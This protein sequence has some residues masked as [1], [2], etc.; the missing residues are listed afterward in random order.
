M[1][2]KLCS[3]SL[4]VKKALLSIG[5]CKEDLICLRYLAK[6]MAKYILNGLIKV[7]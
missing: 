1:C 3:L 2:F 6:Y 5:L 4:C 7:N